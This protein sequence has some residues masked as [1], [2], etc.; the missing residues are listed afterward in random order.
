MQEYLEF[1]MVHPIK[2]ALF[3]GLIVAI[4]TFEFKRSSRGQSVTPTKAVQLMNEEDT[5]LIDIRPQSQFKE[6]HIGSA[7]NVSVSEIKSR[8]E[9]LC[10]EKDTAILLYCSTGLSTAA[11]AN[12][13]KLLGYTNVFT[14]SGG[15]KAWIEEHL[16]LEKGKK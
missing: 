14:L 7:K 5:V 1:M 13:F 4:I 15:I 10:K 3:L 2:V 16:P 6:G 11:A 12:Q 9:K 8:A